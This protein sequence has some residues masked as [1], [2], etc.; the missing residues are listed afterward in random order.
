MNKIDIKLKQIREENRL[1]LMTHVI[2]GYPS[3]QGTVDLVKIMEREGVDMVELQIPFSD[4][5]ADGPTI[6]KACEQAI[7]R[8]VRVRDAFAVAKKLSSEVT[9]PLLFMAYY[10]TIFQYGVEKFCKDAVVAGVSGLIV[11]DMPLE[12]EQEEHFLSYCD[13]YGLYS[14]RVISPVTPLARLKLNARYAKGFVYCSSRQGTTGVKKTLNPKLASYISQVKKIF[15]CPVAVGFGISQKDHLVS[16]RTHADVAVIGSAI[17]D[18][19]SKDLKNY[20]KN[21]QK[22][23]RSLE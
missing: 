4:P 18:V 13:R 16:L 20:S 10:N 23:L 21:V 1:G 19:I 2:V 15:P 17:V 12:E 6:M 7:A 14:I 5:L 22:F 8:G 9:I 3:V 11:P